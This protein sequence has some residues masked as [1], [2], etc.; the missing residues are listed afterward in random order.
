VSKFRTRPESGWK[1]HKELPRGAGGRALCRWCGVE[2]P[3]GR[4]SFCS[5]AC[6]HEHKLRSDP[7]YL[8]EQ[9]FQRDF[10]VCAL[11][12]TDCDKA[13]RVFKALL[14]KAGLKPAQFPRKVERDPG[15]YG[16]LDMFRQQFPWFKP[17]VSPWA[18]D[19]I[20]PVVEGGGEC[21]IENIRTLCLG[22]HAEVTRELRRRLKRARG[23]ES[24]SVEWPAGGS[25]AEVGT[26]TDNN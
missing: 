19:H 23:A 2:V 15:R 24:D 26:E 14:K 8:R 16:A 20:V 5:D 11:C 17:S 4:R 25:S 7:G 12:A 1:N 18:A 21:G 3:K 9:V 13:Y 10:G 6:V 22:C